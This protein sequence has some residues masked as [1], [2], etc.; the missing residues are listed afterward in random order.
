MYDVSNRASFEAMSSWLGEMKDHVTDPRGLDSV[1]IAVCGN[2]VSHSRWRLGRPLTFIIE[3]SWLYSLMLQNCNMI[4]SY[5][6]SLAD[7]SGEE[8]SGATRRTAV[9]GV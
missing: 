7:R 1:V 2:K 8:E 9:G 5:S 6:L 3:C 4:F